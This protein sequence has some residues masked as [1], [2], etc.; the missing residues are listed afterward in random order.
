VSAFLL[1]SVPDV[2]SFDATSRQE[3]AQFGELRSVSVSIDGKS[4]VI[5][6][7][8]QLPNRQTGENLIGEGLSTSPPV[9]AGS[10]RDGKP[11][12]LIR[13]TTGSALRHFAGCRLFAQVDRIVNTLA[14]IASNPAQH[15]SNV[16]L[17]RVTVTITLISLAS[18]CLQFAVLDL[19][20]RHHWPP[21]PS[22]RQTRSNCAECGRT[23]MVCS[24]D[25]CRVRY[26]ARLG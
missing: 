16:I 8:C 2:R 12:T 24:C 18:R 26:Q 11:R 10:A 3:R 25:C 19:Y 20:F 22:S 9:I 14:L 23:H 7:R 5:K 1:F 6:N 13:L 15:L 21:A 17:P 4:A